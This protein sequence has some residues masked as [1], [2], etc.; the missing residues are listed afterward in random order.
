MPYLRV[1]KFRATPGHAAEF[2]SAYGPDGD[3]ARLFR[4]GDGYL[5]TELLHPMPPAAAYVTLDRWRSENDWL[6]FLSAHGADYQAL[7]RRL[8]PLT[9]ENVEIGNFTT[10]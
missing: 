4:L 2:E 10:P 1:W 9:A 3:W 7:A 6:K 8:A 5:G